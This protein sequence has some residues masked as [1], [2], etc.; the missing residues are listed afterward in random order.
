MSYILVT[1]SSADLPW[2]YYKEHDIPFLPLTVTMGEDNFPDDGS[3]DSAAFFR[4]LRGGEAAS[5]SMVSMTAFRECFEPFLQEGRDILYLGLSSAL[6]GTYDN[7]CRAAG[8]LLERYPGREIYICNTFCASLGLGL[9]VHEAAARRDA[10]MGFAELCAWCE[11]TKLKINHLFTVD[12]LMFL[13]R[14]GRVSRASA[15]VGSML[16]IKPMLHVSPDG[17]LIN[18]GKARGRGK[19]LIELAEGV[20]HPDGGDGF[21]TVAVSH[22]DCEAEA[23]FV[24]DRVKDR[25]AV[26]HEIVN[27]LGVTIGAHAGPGT[28]ALFFIGKERKE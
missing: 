24:L 16:G 21:D 25:F 6:S 20:Y 11:E 13:H 10:G 9:M 22:G 1:D 17:N 12:D 3:M 8:E 2:N 23:R 7:A 5:T 4:R 18:H 19:A 26:R 15:V 27:N 14:G 28:V